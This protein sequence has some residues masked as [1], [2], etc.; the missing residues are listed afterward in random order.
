MPDPSLPAAPSPPT[1]DW[2]GARR[3]LVFYFSRRGLA[4]AEDLAQE[5]LKRMLDWLERGGN[6]VGKDGFMK[7]VFGFARN[8]RSE[9]R[10][11]GQRPPSGLAE[12]YPS[13]ENKTWG[14]NTIEAGRFLLQLLEQLP[15]R[16]RVL[17]LAAEETPQAELAAQMNIPISTLRV[18]LHRARAR[19]RE[20]ERGA[21]DPGT[22]T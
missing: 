15:E 3:A 2:K 22:K 5:T 7:L 1:Y 10:H 19:L 8:V 17:I 12:E 18:W 16:D 21:R 9:D 13:V 14:L 20:L 6:I 4:N 11:A